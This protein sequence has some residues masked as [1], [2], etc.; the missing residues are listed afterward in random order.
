MNN[1]GQVLVVFILFIPFLLL[2][3]TYIVDLTYISY[4]T[5]KLNEINNLVINETNNKKLSVTEINEYLQLNDN[6]VEIVNLNITNE[7]IEI[8]L[9]KKVKSLFGNIIGKKEYVLTSTKV[10][11]NTNNGLLIY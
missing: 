6:T 8:T 5:N 7:K 9:K 1:K 4:H 3:G 11:N 2:L 10:I